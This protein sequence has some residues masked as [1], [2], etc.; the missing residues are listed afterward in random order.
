[1][2]PGLPRENVGCSE[3][4]RTMLSLKSFSLFKRKMP[5]VSQR[6]F[7]YC[8][9]ETVILC[10]K[11]PLVPYIQS[12]QCYLEVL[13]YFHGTMVNSF[14]AGYF[15]LYDSPVVSI[16]ERVNCVDSILVKKRCHKIM[17]KRVSEFSISEL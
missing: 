1:M 3:C 15:L 14:P 8:L 10:L 11:A 16:K 9:K 17:V 4:E 12:R 6:F 13:L 7:Q 2:P 5:T